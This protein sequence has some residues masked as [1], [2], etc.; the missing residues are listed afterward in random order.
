MQKAETQKAE[1]IEGFYLHHPD[2]LPA[3]PPRET[4][5]FNAFRGDALA[6]RAAGPLPVHWRNYFRISLVEGRNRP[7]HAGQAPGQPALCFA[8]PQ[9]PSRREFPDAPRGGYC[10]LFTETF[11]SRFGHLRAYPLFKPGASSRFDLTPP[12]AEHVRNLFVR[13]RA[14]IGSDY[15]YKGDVLRTLTFELIHYAL[16]LRPAGV[17]RHAPCTASTR[18]ASLFLELLE[19]QFPVDSPRQRLALR[20]PAGYADAL[21]V[22]VNHLNK[23]LRETTGKTTSGLIAE[24]VAREGRMLLRHTG[25]T[26]GD[27]AWSLGFDELPH[28]IRFFKRHVR[29]TPKSYRMTEVV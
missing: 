13:M 6:D 24:R 11:F 29:L 3:T 7:Y 5:H 25:W 8:A 26:V 15:V 9:A 23:V 1:T 21:A 2:P 20:T 14:E 12:Q 10:C 27:I 18:L 16:R 22:H 19:R 17:S 4:G 28:F